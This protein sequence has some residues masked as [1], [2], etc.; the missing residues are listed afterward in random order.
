MNGNILAAIDLFISNHLQGCYSLAVV[1]MIGGRGCH[2]NRRVK[3]GLHILEVSLLRSSRIAST[4]TS[5]SKP[6]GTLPK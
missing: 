6:R 1:G 5:Q 3:I 2:E 4:A